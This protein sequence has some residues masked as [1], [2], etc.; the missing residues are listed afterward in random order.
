MHKCKRIIEGKTYNTE[1]AARLAG[2]DITEEEYPIT[3]GEHLYQNRFGAF[4][5][6]TYADN[7]PD[8]PEEGLTPYNPE[9]AQAWLQKHRSYDVE[10][11][12]SLFGK[13]PEAG[14]SESKF[15]LRLPDSL[16]DRLA[17]RA[18]KNGQSLNAWIIKC[19]ERCAPPD[20]ASLRQK[21][22]P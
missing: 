9:Q 16:R 22:R 18:K 17:V 1:T 3:H 21:T 14:T 20:E 13:L 15:T 2:W 5:L 19:L 12:E 10:L 7:G 8:G 11:I 4:F 6:Y